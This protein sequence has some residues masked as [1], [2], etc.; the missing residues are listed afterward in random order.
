MSPLECGGNGSSPG[1]WCGLPCD[2]TAASKCSTD[3]AHSLCSPWAEAAA[4]LPQWTR[5]RQGFGSS[6]TPVLAAAG[7]QAGGCC[8]LSSLWCCTWGEVPAC[9][10]CSSTLPFSQLTGPC[11]GLVPASSWTTTALMFRR[12]LCY[13][14][15]HALSS[16]GPCSAENAGGGAA[17]VHQWWCCQQSGQ[18]LANS[19]QWRWDLQMLL[20]N[21]SKISWNWLQ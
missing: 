18:A 2:R 21:Q 14:P 5:G 20:S 7:S 12:L 9:A 13:R 3:L 10:S 11:I 8:A 4:S 19:L 17:F 16:T 6:V 1:W 15:W